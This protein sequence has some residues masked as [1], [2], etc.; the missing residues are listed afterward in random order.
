[1]TTDFDTIKDCLVFYAMKD[2]KKGEEILNCYGVRSNSEFFLHNGFVYDD[3]SMNTV[4][5]KIGI[6]KADP[7]FALKDTLCRK[8]DLDTNGFHEL[9]HR[10][11]RL[12]PRVLATIRI[13]FLDNS[14]LIV[15]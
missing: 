15:F 3:H 13:F 12:N 5:V 7:Q 1:M 6:S 10:D 11:I 4:R 2:Y 8:I 9:E 14:N